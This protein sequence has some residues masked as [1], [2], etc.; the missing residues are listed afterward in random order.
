MENLQLAARIRAFRKLKGYTQQQLASKMGISLAILGEI[1][2]GNRYV[3]DQILNKISE[4]LDI[5]I[6]ELMNISS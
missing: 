3:D 2:R 6:H 5:S 1:E 4:V